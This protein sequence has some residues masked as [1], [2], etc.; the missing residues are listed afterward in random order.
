MRKN[1]KLLINNKSKSFYLAPLF[2]LLSACGGSSSSSSDDEPT[3]GS[4]FDMSATFVKGVVTGATCELNEIAEDGTVSSDVLAT[5]TTTASGVANF[6]GIDHI[7][8][9]VVACS[10]GTYIDEATDASL[11]APELRAVVDTSSSL[12]VA[13]T[14]LTEIAV[15]RAEAEANPSLGLLTALTVYNADNALGIDATTVIPVDIQTEAAEDTDAGNY[16]TL[17]TIISQVAANEGADTPEELL[18]VIQSFA[19]DEITDAD[20]TIAVEDL[21]NSGVTAAANISS[22]ILDAVSEELNLVIVADDG[23]D[24]G[25][26]PDPVVPDPV[27]PDP[28]VPDP[29]VPVPDTSTSVTLTPF[30]PAPVSTE[31]NFPRGTIGDNDSVPEINCDEIY[32]SASSLE[33]AA[34]SELAPGITLC[35]ADGEYSSLELQFGGQGTEE[36]PITVAAENSGGVIVTGASGIRMSGSYVVVQGFTF[37]GGES[38][39]SDFLQTR[40]S[41]NLPCNHCR[42]TE[43]TVINLDD[44]D[45]DRGRWIHL[46]GTHNRVDHSW[47]SGKRTGAPLLAVN[48]EIPEDGTLDDVPENFHII[49]HNYFGNRPPSEGEPYIGVGKNEFEGIQIGTS[50][51]HD[52]NSFTEVSHNYFEQIEGEAEVISNKSGGNTIF[53]NT[54][55]DSYGSITSRHGSSATISHNFVIGDGHPF[56]GGIRIV[57]DGH[58]V[59]N[60]YIEGARF[61]NTRFHGGIVLHNS[62]GSTSNG[63]QTF[64]NVLVANNTITDSVNSLNVNGGRESQNPTDVR[65]VNNIINDAV[66]PIIVGADEGMPTGSV[67]SGNYVEGL[68][69]SDDDDLTSFNGFIHG[70][71]ELEKDNLGIARPTSASSDDL[72]SDLNADISPFTA[73]IDDIDGQTRSTDETTS[74]AD[75]TST[76][77]VVYGILT[78]NDVGPIN[79]RPAITEPFVGRI[80]IANSAFDNGAADWTFTSSA[81]ITTDTDEVFARGFSG[82]I[83]DVA[84]RISQTLT[85]DANT[86]YSL[87]AF[88]RGPVSL[89]V[90]INGVESSGDFNNSSY[91]FSRFDFT[92]GDI[93]EVTIFSTLD[94]AIENNVN[95]IESDFTT[96]DGSA[97]DTNPWVIVEGG[98]IGRVERSSNSATNGTEGSARFRYSNAT[99]FGSPMISQV[100]TDIQPNTDYEVSVYVLADDNITATMGV[101]AG[102]TTTLI[103]SKLLDFDALEAND[104][105]EGDDNFRQDT[106]SFNS[107]DSTSVTLFFAYTANRITAD[108]GDG[109]NTDLRLDDIEITFEGAP[110]DDA[111]A[112]IDEVRLVSFAGQ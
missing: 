99:E 80:N 106:L 96:F 77:N 84:G 49:D 103:N 57:D 58:R 5:S 93:T 30:A 25:V 45:S 1:N 76:S 89:G 21:T 35:L 90:S 41:G 11:T 92:T 72:I 56:A 107:G 66:G 24:V 34:T 68:E 44:I 52:R 14:P 27:V 53:N 22:D 38:A 75:E 81:E 4:T 64:E 97:S 43:I 98:S 16:A 8:P 20:I 7:G 88:T 39:S 63:Y 9:T 73:V 17:L 37:M 60:N 6:S 110:D 95:V 10:G 42:I 55:R 61:V 102:E 108:G 59:V 86:N 28:V 23:G 101:N 91:R 83:T 51:A 62:D 36:N 85:L 70:S 71:V 48:R 40:G 87:T 109:G 65:F 33:D 46:Y 74:G 79:Y 19:N 111:E 100:L 29:V 69:F 54:I 2:V 15:Q 105:P 78:A 31:S 112:L 94:D 104:A 47:F 18:E 26:T 13:V 3:I 67:Y 12:D 32:T 82:K 50:F